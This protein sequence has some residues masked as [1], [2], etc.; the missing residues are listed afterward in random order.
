MSDLEYL[1]DYFKEGGVTVSGPWKL[2]VWKKT[3]SPPCYLFSE[4]HANE[5][6]CP[7]EKD[8]ST[9]SRELLNN[10]ENVHIFRTF[11]TRLRGIQGEA[12]RERG[13]F[14]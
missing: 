1:E 14:F 5:G 7:E 8:I 4:E 11:R 12:N 10:T 3:N 13:L 9:V 6:S 2:T